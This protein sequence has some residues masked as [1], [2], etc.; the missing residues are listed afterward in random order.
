MIAKS[1]T[2][3]DYT[4]TFCELRDEVRRLGQGLADQGDL[5]GLRAEFGS[6]S[7]VDRFSQIGPTAMIVVGG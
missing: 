3:P 6:Q 1:Q 2:R 5:G 4:M 7:V